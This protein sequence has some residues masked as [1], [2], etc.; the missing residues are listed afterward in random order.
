[1]HRDI[2]L[3]GID[4]AIKASD[5][6]NRRDA[7]WFFDPQLRGSCVCVCGG[8][9]HGTASNPHKGHVGDR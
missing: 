6:M 3:T 7:A 5:L 2:L 9:T 1:M 8:Q 4:C